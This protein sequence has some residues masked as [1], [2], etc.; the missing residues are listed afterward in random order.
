[1]ATKLNINTV[2]S[3]SF[4]HIRI[5]PSGSIPLDTFIGLNA[6]P[7]DSIPA[8]TP[9]LAIKEVQLSTLINATFSTGNNDIFIHS[10]DDAHLQSLTPYVIEKVPHQ[11]GEVDPVI[12]AE[13][14]MTKAAYLKGRR[15]I[16]IVD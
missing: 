9:Q 14:V 15:P 12:G 11:A 2:A 10:A 16:K 1:M 7:Y 4:Y 8:D 13:I 5:A 3:A 6:L